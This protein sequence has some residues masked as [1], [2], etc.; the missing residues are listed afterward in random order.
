MASRRLE[1]G[2]EGG[3]VLRMTVSEGSLEEVTGAL[4]PDA[5]RAQV[6]A[7]EGAF[8]IRLDKIVFVRIEPGDVSRVGFG[9]SD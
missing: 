6:E 5:G 2:F 4:S 3:S 8:A 7:E 9:G 1:V